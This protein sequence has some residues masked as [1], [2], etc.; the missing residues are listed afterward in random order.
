MLEASSPQIEPAAVPAQE[1]PEKRLLKCRHCGKEYLF[2][3]NRLNGRKKAKF[4]CSRCDTVFE[5][6]FQAEER[7]RDEEKPE[8]PRRFP[9]SIITPVA[10][11]AAAC[12]LIFISLNAVLKAGT[13]NLSVINPAVAQSVSK[14]GT[15]YSFSGTVHN[16]LSSAVNEVN[17]EVQLFSADS[18]LLS[19]HRVRLTPEL[20]MSGDSHI[21]APASALKRTAEQM[22]FAPGEEFS[23]SLPV[24]ISSSLMP[25]SFTIRAF[26]L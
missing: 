24:L 21:Q 15:L 18:R 5:Q 14:D 16:S 7:A 19:T 23:F 3:T 4:K 20:A 12:I 1:S 9:R 25:A 10:I 17:V 22:T 11:L 13:K 8:T 6:S 2:D 26:T